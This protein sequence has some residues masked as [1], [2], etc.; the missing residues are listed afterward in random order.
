EGSAETG[1][2]AYL[3]HDRFRAVTDRAT[4]GLPTDLLNQATARLRALALLYAFTFF[5]AGFFP[6]LIMPMHR[7][8]M[9][10]RPILWMP[11]AASIALGLMVAWIVRTLPL[12]P[13][14]LIA[15]ALAFEVASSYGIA[16]AEFIQPA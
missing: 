4:T 7:Q 9:F 2:R 1:G 13:R 8:M 3:K 6:A 5:M 12:Q 16:A 14:A 11:G 10:A 15:V